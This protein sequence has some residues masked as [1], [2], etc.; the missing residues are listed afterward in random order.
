V[1]ERDDLEGVAARGPPCRIHPVDVPRK[2]RDEFRAQ[3][4]H[5]FRGDE[6]GRLHRVGH[7]PHVLRVPRPDQVEAADIGDEFLEEHLLQGPGRRGDRRIAGIG[8]DRQADI[9]EPPG[10]LP[11]ASAASLLDEAEP[12]QHP[13]VVSARGGGL[14]HHVTRLRRGHRPCQSDRL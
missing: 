11:A 5:L 9:R 2:Q 8:V 7:V 14:A 1:R 10:P 4:G 12:G 6:H 3:F 13:Q